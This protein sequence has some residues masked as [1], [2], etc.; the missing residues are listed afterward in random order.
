MYAH[1]RF[2]YL[3]MEVAPV[4]IKVDQVNAELQL[5]KQTVAQQVRRYFACL[6]F[7]P[8]FI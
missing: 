6:A 5:F 8:N 2:W 1:T 4:Q 3:Q 7:C